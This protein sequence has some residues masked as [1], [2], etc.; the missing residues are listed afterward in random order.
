MGFS[1]FLHFIGFAADGVLNYPG[2]S[3]DDAETLAHL[4]R[5]Y[6]KNAYFLDVFPLYTILSHLSIQ[7]LLFANY[8]QRLPLGDAHLTIPSP[9]AAISVRSAQT[10]SAGSR[11]G[12][13]GRSAY[14]G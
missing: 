9:L 8:L 14:P 5:N 4:S 7:F 11:N 3:G 13:A 2:L 1:G 10:G 12:R 6:H